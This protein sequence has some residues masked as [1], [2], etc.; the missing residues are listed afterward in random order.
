M[1][2][3]FDKRN[4]EEILDR[5]QKLS[6]STAPQWGKMNVSEMLHHLNLS[7]EAPIGKF[8]TQGKPN[9]LMRVFK[10]VLYSDKKFGKGAP[11]PKEFRVSGQFDFATEKQKLTT[12]LQEI[13][14]MGPEGSYLPHVFFGKITNPQWGMHFYKHVDHHLQ[15]FGV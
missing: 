9:F 3:I 15:Q 11:T 2:T 13:F 7:L 10:S 6:P 4:Y 1:K 14:S 12:N 5:V 8:S